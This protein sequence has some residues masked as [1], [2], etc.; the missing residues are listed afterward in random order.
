LAQ[1]SAVF[2]D[3]L[4]NAKPF[5]IHGCQSVYYGNSSFYDELMDGCVEQSDHVSSSTNALKE[6]NMMT[7]K[8]HKHHHKLINITKDR[9]CSDIADIKRYVTVAVKKDIDKAVYWTKKWA[10]W[11]VTAYAYDSIPLEFFKNNEAIEEVFGRLEDGID[12]MQ[13]KKETFKN[14]IM[15]NT[16]KIDNSKIAEFLYKNV[17]DHVDVTDEH[18][19]ILHKDPIKMDQFVRDNIVKRS[20]YMYYTLLNFTVRYYLEEELKKT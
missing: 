11:A 10:T 5:Y 14:E 2:G 7:K 19:E 13:E 17:V 18:R 1:D 9:V 15:G 4:Y 16:T 8:A 3:A 12:Y 6:K 20:E